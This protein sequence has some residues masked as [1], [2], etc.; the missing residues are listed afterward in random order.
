MA[1]L[2][3]DDVICSQ[4]TSEARFDKYSISLGH[5][6]FKEG[7]LQVASMV[8]PNR[9]F[10]ADRSIILYKIGMLNKKKAKEVEEALVRIVRN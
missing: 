3:G 4:I 10:T 2:Q 6:D 8:R 7:G 1:T 9:L 5:H